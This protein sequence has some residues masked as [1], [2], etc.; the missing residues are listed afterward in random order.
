MSYHEYYLNTYSSH[1]SYN[2][3]SFMNLL[4]ISV[5][6]KVPLSRENR[7]EWALICWYYRKLVAP[8]L[9]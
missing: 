4:T 7:S 6:H 3:P 8:T 5:T 1:Y 2:E 9:P